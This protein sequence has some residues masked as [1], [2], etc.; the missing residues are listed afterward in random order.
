[1]PFLTN[2]LILDL[3]PAAKPFKVS[4]QVVNGKGVSGLVVRVSPGGTKTFAVQFRSREG[5]KGWVP[6]GRF[7]ILTVDQARDEAKK[8]LLAVSRGEDPAKKLREDRDAPTVAEMVQAFKD[9]H[10]PTRSSRTEKEYGRILDKYIVPKLGTRKSKSIAAEDMHDIL[11]EIRKRAPI[12]ANRVMAVARKMF[13]W[14]EA[15]GYRDRGTNPLFGQ[16][17]SVEVPRDRRMNETEIRALGQ[18]IREVR[19]LEADSK[20]KEVDGAMLF[21]ETVHGLAAVQLALLTG[22]RKG[23]VLGL[24]WAWLNLERGVATI[25]ADSHKTGRKTG[26]ARVVYLCPAAVALL[27]ALPRLDEDPEAED[28]NPHVILGERRGQAL[29]QLQDVW[30]HLRD[31]VTG[32]AKHLAKQHRKKTA[33]VVSIEDVTIHDLRRTFASV[34]ADLRIPDLIVKALLGHQSLGSVT[35]VYTRLSAD[36]IRASADEVGSL[37]AG[38]LAGAHSNQGCDHQQ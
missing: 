6:I 22:M 25:P 26:K 33:P 31:A 37:I 12:Q 16:T 14:A 19:V 32:R 18:I 9:D 29:V 36:P 2:K 20:P 11:K 21:P 15:T 7:G 24:R 1:M 38:W 28:Y 10:L 17:W 23:E 13:N 5:R 3:Q 34:A 30:D 8:H 35:E 4:D 27:G